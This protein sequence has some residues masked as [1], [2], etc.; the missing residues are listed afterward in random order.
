M[1]SKAVGRK[2]GPQMSQPQGLGSLLV[3]KA[4]FCGRFFVSASSYPALRSSGLGGSCYHCIRDHLTLP[5]GLPMGHLF[6]PASSSV[7]HYACL[8]I[9]GIAVAAVC[10][11]FARAVSWE[12]VWLGW[13]VCQGLQPLPA[14]RLLPQYRNSFQQVP[15]VSD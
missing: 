7:P 6:R 13:W 2:L 15:A 1:V 8:P 9:P 12:L 14:L 3:L 11:E 4:P 10:L 5:V